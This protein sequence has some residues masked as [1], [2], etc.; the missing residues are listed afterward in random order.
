[1]KD[2]LVVPRPAVFLQDGEPHVRVV[3]GQELELRPVSL[4]PQSIGL[5]VIEG[6]LEP[7]EKVALAPPEE[8]PPA[9]EEDGTGGPTTGEISGFGGLGE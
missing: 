9:A 2:A 7:E 3:R 4:G 1:V 6:G 8:A 5:A